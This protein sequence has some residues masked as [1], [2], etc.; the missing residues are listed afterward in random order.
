M[1]SS[2]KHLL[3][4]R[5]LPLL[6]AFISAAPGPVAFFSAI[7]AGCFPPLLR[8]SLG[9]VGSKALG[10]PLALQRIDHLKAW[11]VVALVPDLDIW[12]C[13]SNP[14]GAKGPRPR[15]L[16]FLLPLIKQSAIGFKFFL[17]ALIRKTGCHGS[18]RKRFPAMWVRLSYQNLF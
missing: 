13:R 1:H 15:F 5:M 3:L 10:P 17:G 18:C 9:W 12:R 2:A 11:E 8:N 7:V 4:G 16:L 14:R 6:F